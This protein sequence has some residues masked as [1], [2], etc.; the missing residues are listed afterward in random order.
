MI[1]A[2]GP[3]DIAL[4][5]ILLFIILLVLATFTIFEYWKNKKS[6]SLSPYTH[7]PLLRATSLSYSAKEKVLKYLFNLHQYDNRIFSFA[8]AALCRETGRLF[9]NCVTWYD[10]IEL[11]WN[12]LQKRYPGNYVSWGS[13][14]QEQQEIV[15]NRH[16]TLEGFQTDFSSPLPQPRAIEARYA[17]AVPGPLYIDIE[18]CI[19]LGWKCI[20]DTDLEVLIVQ[21][22][23]EQD[24]YA[25]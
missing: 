4:F 21:K 17:F 1:A 11:N 18:T 6:N 14:S 24:T 9:I 20:P 13:L 23:I 19:I 7:Q 16:H 22:P 15:R 5:G 3:V 10:K 12:F 25:R 8:H 2:V